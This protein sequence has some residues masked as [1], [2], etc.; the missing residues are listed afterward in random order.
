MNTHSASDGSAPVY[1]TFADDPDY[2]DILNVFV[3]GVPQ[4]IQ[5]L[6]KMYE[7][8]QIAELEC[9]A[10][11]LKGAGGGYGFPGVSETATNLESAC[12][13]SDLEAIS[14]RLDELT[15]YLSRIAAS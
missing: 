11:Q 14:A 7:G 4:R 15:A 9:L 6:K 2:T 8:Q 1:S 10:H 3:E 12:Q 5:S 13:S